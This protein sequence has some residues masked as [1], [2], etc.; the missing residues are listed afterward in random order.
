MADLGY[1]YDCLQIRNLVRFAKK[2]L[3]VTDG[4]WQRFVE[5][6]PELARRRVQALDRYRADALKEE[7]INKFFDILKLAYDKCAEMSDGRPLTAN[8]VFS[9]DEVGFDLNRVQGYMISKRGTKNAFVLSSGNREHISVMSCV[10]ALGY[11]INPAFLIPRK[12][13]KPNLL[14]SSFKESLQLASKSGWMDEKSFIEWT[15]YFVEEISS[16]RGDPQAWC[17][18]ILDGHSSHTS[19][20]DA[21]TILN[22]NRILTVCLPSHSTS[23][24]Q[25]LDV[26]IFHP[27]KLAYTNSLEAHKKQHGLL[28]K[29]DDFPSLLKDPWYKSHTIDNIR[30]GFETTRI[31]PLIPSGRRKIGK[32]LYTS[33]LQRMSNSRSN[34]NG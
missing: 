27:L 4:W 23:I 18:L 2:D 12:R 16:I 32:N 24:L 20:P 30:S 15:K 1:G 25:P 7:N 34:I 17:L 10:S 33:L 13:L 6:H 8:R 9:A 21:L 22:E 14:T 3:R 31:F 28:M 5:R 26:A 29:I 19:S 11:A